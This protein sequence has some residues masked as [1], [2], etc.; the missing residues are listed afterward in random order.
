MFENEVKYRLV[1]VGSKSL[2]Y[3]D[4]FYR[5]IKNQL[6]LFQHELKPKFLELENV[7]IELEVLEGDNEK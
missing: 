3:K 1:K 6:L 5:R 2:L 7:D 4:F